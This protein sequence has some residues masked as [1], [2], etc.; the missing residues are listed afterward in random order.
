MARGSRR[1]EASNWWG[2]PSIAIRTLTLHTNEIAAKFRKKVWMLYHLREAGIK[3][4][5]LFKLYCCYVRSIIE[6]CSPVYHSLLSA[7]KTARLERLQRQAI[8]ICFGFHVDV[9]EVMRQ[10]CIESLESR[11][12]QRLDKF[13]L[14]TFGNPKFAHWF[15]RRAGDGHNIRNRRVIEERRWRTTRAMN[16]S[17]VRRS[18]RSDRYSKSRF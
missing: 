1:W 15:P 4:M 7:G 13:I 8:R 14:K 10:H 3:G 9:Q 2:T 6:Y 12:I 17:L 11:R 5:R 18:P 16:S